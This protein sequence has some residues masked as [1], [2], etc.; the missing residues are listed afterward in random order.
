MT[1]RV[2]GSGSAGGCRSA[3][4]RVAPPS[5][6][7]NAGLV[8][9]PVGTDLR[10]LAG[11]VI[12]T[13]PW[14]CRGGR[15]APTGPGVCAGSRH[16]RGGVAFDQDLRSDKGPIGTPPRC[17]KVV[18]Q[19]LAAG[20]VIKQLC[21]VIHARHGHARR[22]RPPQLRHDGQ[23]RLPSVGEC[24][25]SSLRHAVTRRASSQRRLRV[26]SVGGSGA[27]LARSPMNVSR[28][29]T[30]PASRSLARAA[31]SAPRAGQRW[32]VTEQPP[33]R[34]ASGPRPAAGTTGTG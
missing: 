17:G 33:D 9:P 12:G 25:C 23:R 34:S 15:G 32:A 5:W 19:S 1:T 11:C 16:G 29:S 13:S 2:P 24:A 30:S 18:H 21:A 8:G 31:K 20:S 10:L 3:R 28:P 22:R 27:S 4:A 7:R 6:T 26:T 14:E